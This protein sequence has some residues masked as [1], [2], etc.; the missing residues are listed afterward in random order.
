MRTEDKQQVLYMYR[1]E[2]MSLKQI[3]EALGY[4]I[5]SIEKVVKPPAPTKQQFISKVTIKRPLNG[6]V[7]TT[8]LHPLDLL[9]AEKAK[10]KMAEERIKRLEEKV[11]LEIPDYINNPELTKMQ[12]AAQ[13]AWVTMRRKQRFKEILKKDDEKMKLLKE[14]NCN[15]EKARKALG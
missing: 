3:A 10:K 13:K 4:S 8:T 15:L 7:Q 12:N 9:D 14:A 2:N 1:S 5:G 6:G 11:K